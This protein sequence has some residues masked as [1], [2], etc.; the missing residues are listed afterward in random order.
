MLIVVCNKCY[1]RK[2]T[3]QFFSKKKKFLHTKNAIHRGHENSLKKR[4][5]FFSTPQ[6]LTMPQKNPK[7][8]FQT[9]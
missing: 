6:S 5:V 4:T 2:T 1:R 9:N 7:K 8:P 3:T